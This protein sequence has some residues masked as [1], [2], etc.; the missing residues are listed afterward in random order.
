M[1]FLRSCEAAMSQI[2]GLDVLNDCNENQK[3]L[4]KLP[5]W[6]TSRW[7]RKVMEVEEQSRTFPSFSQFVAFLTCEAK[8]ACN[9]VTSLDAL[10]P[11]EGDKTKAQRNRSTSRKILATNSDKRPVPANCILLDNCR[12]FMEREVSE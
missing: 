6:L 12:R 9:P 4:T 1:D 2:K 11:S 5:D 10:K 3:I 8:I 7:N